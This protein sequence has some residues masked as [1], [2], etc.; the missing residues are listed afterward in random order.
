MTDEKHILVT[1]SEEIDKSLLTSSNYTLVDSTTN[2]ILKVQYV[3]RKYGK[4]N[5]L[6]YV[7]EDKLNIDNSVYLIAYVL[8]D[9]LNNKYQNDFVH[10]TISD[11]PDTSAVNVIATEPKQNGTVDFVDPKIKFYFDDGFDKKDVQK[12]I[13][14]LNN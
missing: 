4:K 12:N 9:T 11:R 2:E 3:F 1:I 7:P 6:I 5:E 14:F 8:M 13:T 10:L